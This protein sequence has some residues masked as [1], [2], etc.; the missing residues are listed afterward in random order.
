MTERLK[1]FRE[2]LVWQKAHRLFLDAVGDVEKFPRTRAAAIITDQL[3]RA[4]GSISANVAEGYGR[5]A[6]AEYVHFLTIARGSTTESEN[7][8]IK[9]GDLAYIPD[10]FRRIAAL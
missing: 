4:V 10:P 8:F 6:G 2:L 3:L 5:H 9:C 7:W 1:S